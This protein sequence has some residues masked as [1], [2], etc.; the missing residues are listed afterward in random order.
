M[1]SRSQAVIVSTTVAGEAAANE[2]ARGIVESRLAACVQ[3]AN[4]RSTY[5]W[6][7]AIESA[8]EILLTCKTRQDLAERLMAFIRERHSYEVPEILVTPVIDGL[9]AYL[10]WVERETGE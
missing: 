9:P 2:L 5:R 3:Q 6:K 4:I 8:D 10:E 7:G 1:T